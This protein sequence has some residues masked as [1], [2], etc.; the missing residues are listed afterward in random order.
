MTIK[1]GIWHKFKLGQA[2]VAD[3][4]SWCDAVGIDLQTLLF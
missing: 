4:S 3:T 2:P 1:L